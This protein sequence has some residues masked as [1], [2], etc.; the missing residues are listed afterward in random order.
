MTDVDTKIERMYELAARIAASGFD[1]EVAEIIEIVN[2]SN[3]L[4]DNEK[5]EEA[6]YNEGYE[7]GIKEGCR[8]TNLARNAIASLNRTG[9]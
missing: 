9:L 2:S 4:S 3:N 5:L 8:R 1:A 7:D 6:A